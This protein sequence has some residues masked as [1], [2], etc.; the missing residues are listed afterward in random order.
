MGPFSVIVKFQTSRIFISSSTGHRTT[1]R[2]VPSR[3]NN[4]TD[5][6]ECFL[7]V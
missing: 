2:G 5:T 6:E 1:R 7:Q 4:E 3:L